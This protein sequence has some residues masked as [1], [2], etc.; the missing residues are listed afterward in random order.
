MCSIEPETLRNFSKMPDN[1]AGVLSQVAR[2]HP[3]HQ[4]SVIL[5]KNP[6]VVFGYCFDRAAIFGFQY[7]SFPFPAI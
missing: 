6:V 3:L 4:T 1:L 5:F 7:Y 2:I